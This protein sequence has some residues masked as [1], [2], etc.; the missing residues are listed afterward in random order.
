MR[1]QV[2]RLVAEGWLDRARRHGKPGRPVDVFSLAGQSRGLFAQR[3][4]EFVRALLDEVADTEGESKLRSVI[5]GVGRRLASRLR[6]RVGEG[7]AVERVRR[8]ADLLHEDG[9]LND[10]IPSDRSVTLKI[11]TCPYHGLTGRRR[12]I[13]EMEREMVSQ[14]VGAE[15]RLNRCMPDG[16]AR[17]ELEVEVGPC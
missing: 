6:P 5:A 2:D 1:Q 13:C 16:H 10:A 9:A 4:D 8:L 14:L 3:T 12:L 7:P 17:C 15:T 11:H